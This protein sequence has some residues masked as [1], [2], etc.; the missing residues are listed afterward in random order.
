MTPL[1]YRRRAISEF[2][3][4]FSC[5][6]TSGETRGTR[7]SW[8]TGVRVLTVNYR[9][10]SLGDNFHNFL[11]NFPR[12]WKY[13][14]IAT[15]NSY[16]SRITAAP[17]ASSWFYF[18]VRLA[19]KRR[20]YRNP[21]DSTRRWQLQPPIDPDPRRCTS[22]EF[23]EKILAGARPR[24]LREL[25]SLKRVETFFGH[26]RNLF[27]RLYS[28]RVDGWSTLNL[29]PRLSRDSTSEGWEIARYPTE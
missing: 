12:I 15:C 26:A 24:P 19:R 5:I 28:S 3:V 18:R 1:W 25:G 20:H 8:A 23:R 22:G 17:V 14:S 29:H 16:R 10:S 9:P 13:L 4:I 27:P 21:L 6:G 7:K 2:F 11:H